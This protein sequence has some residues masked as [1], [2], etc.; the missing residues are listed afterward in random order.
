MKLPVAG[1]HHARSRA[2]PRLAPTA[3]LDRPIV[4]TELV[5]EL[6]ASHVA[7]RFFV[8]LHATQCTQLKT[9]N[10]DQADAKPPVVCEF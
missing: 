2:G 9:V 6:C 7:T 3:I 8:C 4:R 5:D 10:A 1:T